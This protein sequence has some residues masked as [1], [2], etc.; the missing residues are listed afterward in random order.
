MVLEGCLELKLLELLPKEL[1]RKQVLLE[2]A[3]EWIEE[4]TLSLLVLL[5]LGPMLEELLLLLF[6]QCQ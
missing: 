4:F 3:E 5:E 1:P 6:H 2:Q